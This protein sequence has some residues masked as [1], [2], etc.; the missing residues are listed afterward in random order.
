MIVRSVAFCYYVVHLTRL[1]S[2][3]SSSCRAA[4]CSKR[5]AHHQFRFCALAPGAVDRSKMT[6]RAEAELARSKEVDNYFDSSCW[7]PKSPCHYC[8]QQPSCSSLFL[9]L[10][11]RRKTAQSHQLREAL[12]SR[13]ALH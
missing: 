13:R 3:L 8:L 5:C 4:D 11:A 6:W 12:S 10:D 9:D 1:S 2:D 7:Y